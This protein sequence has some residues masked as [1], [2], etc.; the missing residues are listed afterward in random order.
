MQN[1][2]ARELPDLGR[3]VSAFEKNSLVNSPKVDSLILASSEC[4]LISDESARPASPLISNRKCVIWCENVDLESPHRSLSGGL[5]ALD[6][7]CR[8]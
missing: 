4:S 5:G 6:T 8:G 7:L 1:L 3:E 2:E